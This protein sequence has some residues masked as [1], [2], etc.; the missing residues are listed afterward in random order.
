[1][2]KF[3]SQVMVSHFIGL[4]MIDCR[5]K[6]VYWYLVFQISTNSSILWYQ[7]PVL[8]SINSHTNY[9]E[10]VQTAKLKGSFPLQ[11]QLKWGPQAFH[12]FFFPSNYKCRDPSTPLRFGNS[13]VRM[14]R[15]TQKSEFY[16]KR[17]NPGTAQWKICIGQGMDEEIGRN[18]A[19]VCLLS[20]GSIFSANQ[21]VHQLRSSPTLAVKELYWSS[22]T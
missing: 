13:L 8:Q 12:V 21:C 22:I 1:M 9:P 4:K 6:M 3:S 14:T 10:L 11:K 5:I 2:H 7:L 20:W 19:S 18:R 15:R 16:Y 17:Y